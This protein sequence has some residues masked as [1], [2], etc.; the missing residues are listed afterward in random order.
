VRLTLL[1]G[2]AFF[3]FHATAGAEVM[4]LWLCASLP[5]FGCG[6]A[7]TR[8]H[9]CVDEGSDTLRAIRIIA[10]CAAVLMAGAAAAQNRGPQAAPA[11]PYQPVAI[12]LPQP[13]TDASFEAM[14]KQLGEAAQRKD[15]AAMTRLVVAKGFFWDRGD[16]N[17]ADKRKSGFD[18][19]SA[20]LG[21]ANKEG[22][23]WDILSGY[24]ED[25]DASPSPDHPGAMCAPANPTF[26]G[27]AFDDLIKTTNTDPT[28][29]GYPVSAGLEVHATARANGPVIDKLGLHF[30]RIMPE[31]TSDQPS[32]MRI[33]TPSGK[34][35]YVT[36]DSIAP[37]G[38]DKICYI[39][40]GGAWKVGGYIGGGEPQ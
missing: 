40:E 3:C 37:I 22:A 12:T 1:S 23:G 7:C 24:A 14:R 2:T 39:K 29:W 20:A 21:L 9:T 15:R 17:A 13:M 38:Y 10:A 31:S 4:P 27:R 28:E 6:A 36:I 32:Y 33:A 26:D 35:G 5:P 30:V 19:L 34:T 18:N 11:T 25:P 16:G 8:R